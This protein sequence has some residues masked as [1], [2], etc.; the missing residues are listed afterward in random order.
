MSVAVTFGVFLLGGAGLL[1]QQELPFAAGQSANVYERLAQAT[2]D[3]EQKEQVRQA[4]Q[5]RHYKDAET[6]L[7]RAINA[8]P[9]SADLLTLVAGVFMLDKNA[10]NTAI[11]LKKAE[12]IR[13]LEAPD[14]FTLAMAYIAM[15]KRVWARPELD[16]LARAEPQNVRYSYWLARLDYDDRQYESAVRR[17]REVVGL[18]PTFMKAWDN[19]GLSLEALGRID[20]AIASYKQAVRLNRE[21]SIGSAW[22]SLNLGTLLTKTGQLAEAEAYLRE[23][24][25]YDQN[26]SQAHYRLGTN[27]YKQGQDIGAVAEL[28]QAADLDPSNPE[29][30]YTLGQIYR[31]TGDA[32]AAADVFRKFEALKKNRRGMISK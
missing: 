16:R 22:P 4:L 5:A 2:L 6:L 29:P 7:L 18:D 14:R 21:Q 20:E 9:N 15:G 3:H 28:R 26:L 23:A 19:L 10:L 8:N 12:R 11:S 13:T 25:G 24:V 1:A 32:K 30:L 17:L 27:F 31:N